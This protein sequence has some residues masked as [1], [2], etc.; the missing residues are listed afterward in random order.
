MDLFRD[1]GYEPRAPGWPGDSATDAKPIVIGHSFGGLIV[2]RLLAG[3]HASAV[4]S[5]EAAVQST[6]RV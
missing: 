6:S 4:V 1:S 3:G 5:D 2:Q